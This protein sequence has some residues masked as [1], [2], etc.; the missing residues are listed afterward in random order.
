MP[1]LLEALHRRFRLGVIANQSEGTERRLVS[2]GI[3]ERF[4]EILAS[5]KMGL[6]KP[7][8]AIFAN[9]ASRTGCAADQRAMVGDRIDN[10]I[11]PAN[12]MGWMTVRVNQGFSRNDAPRSEGEIADFTVAEVAEV[13]ALRPST[14]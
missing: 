13:A 11:A 7:D 4:D 10:D 9:A 14:A 5:P 8:P 3:R 6:E 2:N 12:A 1:E